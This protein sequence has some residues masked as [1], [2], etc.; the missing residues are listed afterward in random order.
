MVLIGLPDYLHA[1][2]IPAEHMLHITWLRSV[3]SAEYRE[4]LYFIE[5]TIRE[6]NIHLWLCDSRK[7]TLVTYEDQQWI[8]NE[9]I[10]LL[11]QTNIKKVARVVKND[12]FSYITFENLISKAHLS[13]QIQGHME[14][15][16]TLDTALGWLRMPE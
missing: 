11:L 10:P 14:H 4:G 9:I 2:I 6:N 7:L 1:N 12:I 15:F 8:I 5:R 3:D 13:Y 16:T